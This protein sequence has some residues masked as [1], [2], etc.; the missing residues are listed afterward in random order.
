MSSSPSHQG[1]FPIAVDFQFPVNKFKFDGSLESGHWTVY[2]P[3][4]FPSRDSKILIYLLETG[5]APEED[6]CS[7]VHKRHP[8]RTHLHLLTATGCYRTP[9][10]GYGDYGLTG[11]TFF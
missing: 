11:S 1:P 2:P 8:T 4:R 10:A 6:P 5:L 9:R 3:L 7:L